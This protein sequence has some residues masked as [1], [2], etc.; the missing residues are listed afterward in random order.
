MTRDVLAGLPT[1]P[2]KLLDHTVNLTD[3]VSRA[4]RA[5]RELRR[6]REE[7]EA[8][9]VRILTGHDLVGCH[10]VDIINMMLTSLI[11]DVALAERSMC[12]DSP[13]DM[14]PTWLIRNVLERLRLAQRHIDLFHD[15]PKKEDDDA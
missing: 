11:G 9:V 4:M 13:G 10:P 1:D 14:D 3:E 8:E 5:M 6:E 7:R 2:E 12:D 15:V